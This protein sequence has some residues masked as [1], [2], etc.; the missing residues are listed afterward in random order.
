MFMLGDSLTLLSIVAAACLS[1]WSLMVGCAI[2]FGRKAAHAKVTLEQKPWRA[3]AYGV[4][5]MFTVGLVAIVML[6]IPNPAMKVLG[7]SLM[8]LILFVA[9]L[10][11]SG[12]ALLVGNRIQPLDPDVAPFR[13]L[14]RGSA[15]VV[16]AAVMPGFGWFFMLPVILVMGLGLGVDA[17]VHRQVRPP[18]A[19]QTAP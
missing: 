7:M 2:L 9:A 18:V 10:G 15:L 12:M 11:A 16:A 17:L 13:A 8:F 1:A 19:A 5:C 6:S 14:S 4:V 3:F